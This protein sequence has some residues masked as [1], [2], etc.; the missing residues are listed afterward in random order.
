M[1]CSCSSM[2]LSFFS[3]ISCSA[4]WLAH[5][6]A[7]M[8]LLTPTPRPLISSSCVPCSTI[9]PASITTILSQLRTVLSRCATNTAVRPAATSCRLCRMPTSVAVSS[10]DVASSASSSRGERRKARAMATRCFSPP[11]SFT[12]RSP[13]MVLRPSGMRVSV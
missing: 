8:P 10:A 11:L 2:L 9:R 6:A 1:A 5:M 3:L 7:Y 4:C 12:P 13:T